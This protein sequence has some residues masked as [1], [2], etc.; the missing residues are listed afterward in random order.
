MLKLGEKVIYELS[1]DYFDLKGINGFSKTNKNLFITNLGNI[2]IGEGSDLEELDGLKYIYSF[3]E[4]KEKLVSYLKGNEIFVE[5]IGFSFYIEENETRKRARADIKLVLGVVDY[6]MICANQRDFIFTIKDSQTILSINGSKNFMGGI[7]CDHEKFVFM[8]GKNRFEVYFSDIEREVIEEGCISLKG[9]FHIER[10]GIVA[11]SITIF[12]DDIK[13]IITSNLSEIIKYNNKIGNL[14]PESD[15]VFCKITGS[16]NGND[17]K[18]SNTLMIRYQD[19]LIF[20]NKKT[21]KQLITVNEKDCNKISIDKDLIIY[22]GNNV[23]N[24]YINDKNREIMKIDTLRNIED[25]KVGYTANHTPFLIEHF[26]ESLKISKYKGLDIL[27]IDGDKIMDIV[28]DNKANLH[29]KGYVETKIIFNNQV[30]SLYLRKSMTEKLITDIFSLSKREM[31]KDSTT[32]EIYDN[33][34]KSMND[35]LVYNFFSKMY[36]VKEE[37]DSKLAKDLNDEIR[38]DLVNRLYRDIQEQKNDLDL[39]SAYY[40]RI[41]YAQNEAILS[42]FDVVLNDA[43]SSNISSIK[44][45]V[46][47]LLVKFYRHL[48]QIEDSLNKIIFVISEDEH[49]KYNHRLLKESDSDKLEIFLRQA[50]KRLDHFVSDMYPNYIEEIS[51]SVRKVF[52]SLKETYVRIDND[53]IKEI[54]FEKITETYVFKQ[55]PINEQTNLRRKDVLNRLNNLIDRGISSLDNNKFFIGKNTTNVNYSVWDAEYKFLDLSSD[56]RVDMCYIEIDLDKEIQANLIEEETV[57]D[58]NED[59]SILGELIT[60]MDIDDESSIDM[61]YQ[62]IDVDIDELDPDLDEVD[63]D[64]DIDDDIKELLDEI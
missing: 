49:K 31:L 28:V 3:S 21:K 23:F 48:N 22:D 2:I 39:L 1:S 45:V 6:E 16:I 27:S 15:V 33:W 40:P 43:I 18:N 29:N 4:N 62:E 24:L 26:K 41:I 38:I 5:G 63:F 58:I 17:Y 47:D 30:V 51:N 9:Y 14:P 37:L 60:E 11:R 42:E 56:N 20:V 36:Y 61:A 7:N 19:Q 34:A 32:E 50:S 55:L 13:N 8:G 35:M 57:D 64:V 53:D 46:L 10:L 59:D 25:E 52:D 44:N 54:L 12:N